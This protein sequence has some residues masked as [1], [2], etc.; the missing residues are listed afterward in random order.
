MDIRLYGKYGLSG[1]L[2]VFGYLFYDKNMVVSIILEVIGVI[3]AILLIL[4]YN[5]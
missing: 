3:S 4:F 2:I 1:L 5:E